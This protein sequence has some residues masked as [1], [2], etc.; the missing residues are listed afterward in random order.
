MQGKSDSKIGQQDR[1]DPVVQ[2]TKNRT[3]ERKGRVTG[4]EPV[5]EFGYYFVVTLLR[6]RACGRVRSL[7]VDG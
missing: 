4:I 6:V 2:T 5:S 1:Q 7:G 3:V